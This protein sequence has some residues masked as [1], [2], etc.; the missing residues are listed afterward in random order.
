MSQMKDWF[1]KEK[2][3]R[4]V[5]VGFDICPE[6]GPVILLRYEDVPVAVVFDELRSAQ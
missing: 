4:R 3:E 2:E 6:A 1:E 5:G